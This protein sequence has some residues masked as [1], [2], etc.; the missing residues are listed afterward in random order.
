MNSGR[1][2]RTR[3]YSRK[4]I[5]YN[6]LLPRMLTLGEEDELVED[7]KEGI[8]IAMDRT[9]FE[10]EI[11]RIKLNKLVY[12]AIRDNSVPITYGW[13][14]YGPSPVNANQSWNGGIQP[15]AMQDIYTPDEARMPGKKRNAPNPREYSYYF[16]DLD[17]FQNILQEETKEYLIDFYFENAPEGYCDL[18]IACAEFQQEIDEIHGS[19][20]WHSDSERY[21][22]SISE[23]YPRVMYEVRTNPVLDES[24]DNMQQY[25]EVLET[26]IKSASDE[27]EISHQQQRY[28]DTLIGKFYGEAWRHVALL[29][30]RETV[31]LSPGENKSKLKNS[32]ENDLQ[33]LRTS[34]QD[35]L[36][37]LRERAHEYNLDNLSPT[38]WTTE[39]A[40]Q[41]PVDERLDEIE[42]DK[43]ASL[44]E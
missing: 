41:H 3:F 33:T 40:N 34:Y 37:S 36:D 24:V 27:S 14:K 30:S 16:E 31:H 21:I 35:E 5:Y 8:Q 26:V 28:I 15:K 20:D 12:L 19:R 9:G 42:N 25:G 2:E 11:D 7:I 13:Y 1:I 18:Y 23:K 22:R 39:N 43:T 44:I 6:H 17:S 4:D 32:I 38:N 29:I 10:G